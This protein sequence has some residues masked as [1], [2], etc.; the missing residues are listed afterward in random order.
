MIRM[1]KD[2]FWTDGSGMVRRFV[3]KLLGGLLGVN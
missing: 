1:G 2:G 3:G